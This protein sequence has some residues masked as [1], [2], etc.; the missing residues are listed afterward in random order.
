VVRAGP[1]KLVFNTA[2]ALR[3][4]YNSRMQ[5]GVSLTDR[6]K[7][8]YNNERVSKSHVY[9]VTMQAS[10]V[11]NIF[12]VID[13]QQHRAKRK[14]VGQ[15]LTPRSMTAFE[16]LIR[17]QITTFL[18]LIQESAQAGKHV[19]MT[20]PSLYLGL[21]IVGLLSFG[22]PLETQTSSKHRFLAEGMIAGNFFQNMRMQCPMLLRLRFAEILALVSDINER[23]ARYRKLI[24]DMISY[25]L[26]KDKNATHDFYSI[27]ADQIDSGE[28]GGI[29]KSE[30]WAEAILFM[31]AGMFSV[32]PF[33]KLVLGDGKYLIQKQE[34]IQQPP[35]LP[36]CFSICRGI[37]NA[38]RLLLK[39]FARP[40]KTARISVITKSS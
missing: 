13:K 24:A 37:R 23:R 9:L 12:D 21:D 19:N 36:P 34:G 17:N 14:L 38:T 15:V 39:R 22:F 27:T 26:A 16:P 6:T 7:D 2:R 1:N 18:Q 32:V 33:P 28:P 35:P 29:T 25:R 31:Q 5:A 11:H 30:L 20:P 8:I 40:L 10:G 4:T 3:G